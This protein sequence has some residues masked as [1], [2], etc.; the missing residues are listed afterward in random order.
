ML[1]GDDAISFFKEVR[2][3]KLVFSD[4]IMDDDMKAKWPIELPRKQ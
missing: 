3:D 2:S 4:F 1:S